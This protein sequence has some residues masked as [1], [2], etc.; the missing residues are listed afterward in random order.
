VDAFGISNLV[1]FSKAVPKYWKPWMPFWHKYVGDPDL[2]EARK[3]MKARSPLFRV[4]QIQRPL[5]IVQGANDVRVTQNE[6]DQ[7]VAALQKDGKAVDYILFPNEGHGIRKW[8]NRLFFY[9][10]LEDFLA[11]HLGGRSSGFD[12]YE[13]GT[14]I[15]KP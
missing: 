5:L 15:F 3:R 11:K 7:M 14:L 12:Y 2:P 10:R 13:L 8:Q 6:S 9:R 4:H 1:S